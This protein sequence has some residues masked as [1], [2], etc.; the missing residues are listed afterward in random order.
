VILS[1]ILADVLHVQPGDDIIVEVLEGSQVVRRVPVEALVDDVLGT[2]AYMNVDAL[3]RL[4]RED[5]TLS[6]AALVVDPS[7][8]RELAS[9][10]KT[11][12]AVAG[13]ASRRVVLGNFRQMMDENMGVMLTFNILFAGVIAFGVVYNAARVSLSERSRELASL[14]VLG[15]TRAEIS[16]ILLGELAVLTLCALPVGA[17]IGHW[18]T[19]LLVGSIESEMFRFPLVFDLQAVALAALTVTMASTVSGLLVRRRLD[20]LDL[21][22]VLKLRE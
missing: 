5:A 8:E 21:V 16:G 14:R 4:M 11:V 1:A 7:R 12:P 18:L 9:V 22:G 10:L 2:S 19:A 3:H 13:V 6:G 20:H 17:A 15:F